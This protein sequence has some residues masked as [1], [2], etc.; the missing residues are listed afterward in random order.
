MK[1]IN[2]LGIRGVAANC[3]ESCLR[4]KKPGSENKIQSERKRSHSQPGHVPLPV[5]P[6]EVTNI[7]SGLI[8]FLLFTNNLLQYMEQ[9]VKQ[10]SMLIV[11][12]NN[13]RSSWLSGLKIVTF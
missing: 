8:F 2:N 12:E 4:D 1:K 11:L 13:S 5:K 6:R 10:L 3:L 9:F 7:R